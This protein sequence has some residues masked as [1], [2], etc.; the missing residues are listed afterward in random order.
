MN[1]TNTFEEYCA[2]VVYYMLLYSIIEEYVRGETYVLSS[3]LYCVMLFLR[4]IHY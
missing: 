1:Y 2:P 4:S 3:R